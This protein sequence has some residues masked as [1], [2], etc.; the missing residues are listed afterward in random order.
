MKSKAWIVTANMGYGH[1]RTT[2][3]L[4]HLALGD[5]IIAANNYA[6]ISSNDLKIWK[7]SREFY[8]SIS[9]FT[10]IPLIGSGIFAI[11]DK[12]Q[13][14]LSFYPKRDLS[15]HSFQLDVIF[16]LIKKGWGKQMIEKMI[17]AGQG[18][19]NK[20]FPPFLTSFFVPAFMAEVLGYPGEIFC[21]ICDADI[22]RTWASLEPE[23]SRIKYFAPNQRVEERLQLYGVRKENIFLTGYPL[24]KENIGTVK[25]GILKQDLANRI[26]NLDPNKRY[27]HYYSPLVKKYIGKLPEKSDHPLTIMFAVGGAGAQKENGI[28]I[29]KSL[30]SKIRSRQV[31]II[32]VAGIKQKVKDYFDKNI[33]KLGLEKNK[34]I[35]IVFEKDINS[36]FEKFNQSLRKTDILY[37]KPSELSFYS[38]LGIP[39][40]IAPCIGS[41][42]QFNKRWLLSAGF[43]VLQQDPRYID[44]WLFDWIEK[45]Y[46]A[47]AAV[48]AFIEGEQL[49]T[50]KI[51]DI[52]SH[53]I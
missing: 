51:E 19:K 26:I 16:S 21:I 27:Q 1:Q 22:A 12:L 32:L 34:N 15:Q 43:G 37:T 17:S 36:Y 2:Y 5:G 42:E 52:I 48:E 8:E 31:K 20:K 6:G 41:Q 28:K 4:R 44:Q 25:M 14:I 30:F 29:I 53:K 11:Y 49:G 38:A 39:I 7:S 40:I 46:L 10:R 35:E 47:E 13:E 50:F 9:R 18:K 33:K 24:P 23:K 3:P 45:G